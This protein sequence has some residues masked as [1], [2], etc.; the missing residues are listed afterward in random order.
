MG[1]Q[2]ITTPTGEEMVVMSRGEYDALVA[3]TEDAFEDGADA[4]AFAAALAA[5]QPEDVLPAEISAAILRGDG[6]VRA[7]RAWRGIDLASLAQSVDLT[8]LLL[9]QVETGERLLDRDLAARITQALDL[10]A[11]WLNG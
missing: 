1:I 9:E 6:R 8:P 7:F 3:A 11:G 5:H 2:T 10:P 4:A